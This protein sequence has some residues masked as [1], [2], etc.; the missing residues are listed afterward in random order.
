MFTNS[1][2][3]S[4]LRTYFGDVPN[5]G[6]KSVSCAINRLNSKLVYGAYFRNDNAFVKVQPFF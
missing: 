2:G 3:Y 4:T 5:V 6:T 1:R